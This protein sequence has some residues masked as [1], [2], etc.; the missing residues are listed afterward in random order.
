MELIS[1]YIVEK[2]GKSFDDPEVAKI[3]DRLIA[4]NGF[5]SEEDAIAQG[6]SQELI[7]F[8]VRNAYAM[9]NV[10]KYAV[11]TETEAT[12][13]ELSEAMEAEEGNG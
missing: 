3:K 8:S 10:I 4:S 12:E 2:E 13:E 7:D 6:V 11:I 1:R 5:A 9:D